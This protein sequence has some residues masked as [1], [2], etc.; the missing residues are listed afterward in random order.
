MAENP[1][2]WLGLLRWLKPVAVCPGWVPRY[3]PWALI[4]RYDDVQ[5]ALRQDKIFTVLFAERTIEINDGPN[6]VNGGTNFMLTMDDGAGYQNYRQQIMQAFTREDV[7]SVVA[8]LSARCA[9]QIV[10]ESRG[11]LDAVKDLITRVPIEIC[12]SYYGID[13][14]NGDEFAEW[15]FAISPYIFGDT[16]NKPGFRRAALGAGDRLRPLIN[17]S[18]RTPRRPGTVLARLVERLLPERNSLTT[19]EIRAKEATIRAIMIGMV[20]GFVPTDTFAGGHILDTLL[21]RPD[22]LER[23][24]AA[25]LANDDALLKRCLFEALRFKNVHFGPLR[26]C[27][28]EYQIRGTRI[29]QGKKVLIS[30]QAAMFDARRVNEPKQFNPDRPAADNMTLG[31]GLHWCIGVLIAEAQLVETFKALLVREQ[32]AARAG[33]RREIAAFWPR[34]PDT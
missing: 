21:R 6:P 33:P 7:S 17:A 3:G 28:Q 25:A 32:S 19:A 8:P 26:G 4:T 12:R 20:T 13:I 16:F 22:A 31:Y 34:R 9:R 23:A 29:P 10:E 14:P 15:S 5:E 18:I 30:T 24:R 27:H 2:W 1:L 11:R